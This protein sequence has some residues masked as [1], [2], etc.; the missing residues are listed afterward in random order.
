MS[1]RKHFRLISDS[2]NHRAVAAGESV[3]FEVFHDGHHGPRR[4]GRLV[5][6][7]IEAV[8]RGRFRSGPSARE[9]TP[10]LDQE[11]I[12]EASDGTPAGWV[13]LHITQEH[14]G[15]AGGS[16]TSIPTGVYRIINSRTQDHAALLDSNEESPVVTIVPGLHAQRNDGD[17]VRI[18]PSWHRD[19]VLIS[20]TRF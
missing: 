14:L 19:F 16:S 2:I 18:S 9:P 11:L 3:T 17:Q 12:F 15:T 10:V 5:L 4:L 6:P 20:T 8:G 1:P 13:T 7:R